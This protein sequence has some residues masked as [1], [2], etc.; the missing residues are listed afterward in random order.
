MLKLPQVDNATLNTRWSLSSAEDEDNEPLRN[1]ATSVTLN[2]LAQTPI[3][4]VQRSLHAWCPPEYDQYCNTLIPPN[5]LC[6][7]RTV[8]NPTLSSSTPTNM[9]PRKTSCVYYN[10]DG[11]LA[12]LDFPPPSNKDGN[13]GFA[14]SP[15]TTPLD[16]RPQSTGNEREGVSTSTGDLGT[17]GTTEHLYFNTQGELATTGARSTATEKGK[18]P[19]T[20]PATSKLMSMVTED[21]S[22]GCGRDP[23]MSDR[24]TNLDS[25]TSLDHS[26]CNL[27]SPFSEVSPNKN[28]PHTDKAFEMPEKTE[29]RYLPD[30]SS[31]QS[32]D[33]EYYNHNSYGWNETGNGEYYNVPEIWRSLPAHVSLKQHQDEKGLL[34]SVPPR[35]EKKPTPCAQITPDESN[36]SSHNPSGGASDHVEKVRQEE[37]GSRSS[38]PVT[39]RRN[40]KVGELPPKSDRERVRQHEAGN[41]SS[42]PVTPRKRK[43]NTE[44]LKL[45]WEEIRQQEVGSRPVAPQRSRRNK[46]IESGDRLKSPPVSPQRQTRSQFPKVPGKESGVVAH[47][48][49]PSPSPRKLKKKVSKTHNGEGKSIT[50]APTSSH[51]VTLQKPKRSEKLGERDSRSTVLETKLSQISPRKPKEAAEREEVPIIQNSK[52]PPVSPRKPKSSKKEG[53]PKVGSEKITTPLGETTPQVDKVKVKLTKVLSRQQAEINK[54]QLESTTLAVAEKLKKC[55]SIPYQ[56]VTPKVALTKTVSYEK[57]AGKPRSA[58]CDL[59]AHTVKKP[60]LL[61]ARHKKLSESSRFGGNDITLHPSTN[62]STQHMLISEPTKMGISSPD[63]SAGSDDESECNYVD[64]M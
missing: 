34:A 16:E 51:A 36:A 3:E 54:P 43:K 32:E 26:Y 17:A 25:S 42:P 21:N 46:Q 4:E 28:Q 44:G 57:Q 59:Q 33:H 45:V 50:S 30:Q 23:N 12:F 56:V 11:I 10:A 7:R 18:W 62:T 29:D 40:K 14:S 49:S 37:A 47:R 22:F 8:S 1:G 27:K 63:Q 58:D 24:I 41:R 64:I 13:E 48:L 38:P 20:E 2:L 19:A 52:T 53:L 60:M 55:N 15:A 6:I 9:S 39:P 5:S 31:T 35:R 61:P